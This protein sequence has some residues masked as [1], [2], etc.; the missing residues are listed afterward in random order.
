MESAKSAHRVELKHRTVQYGR[1]VVLSRKVSGFYGMYFFI[2]SPLGAS[3]QKASKGLWSIF[4]YF[5]I[6]AMM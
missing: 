3:R 5:I 1:Q 4:S 2:G 6:F